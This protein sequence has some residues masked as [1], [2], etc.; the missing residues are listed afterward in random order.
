M[1]VK[2]TRQ[3]SDDLEAIGD[4]IARDN[5]VRAK[6]FVL[7]LRDACIGLGEFPLRYPIARFPF[8]PNVRQ[9]FHGSHAIQYRVDGDIVW[10]MHIVH[11]ARLA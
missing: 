4:H 9:R 3:A 6:S 7:E 5:P 10:I 2:F 11:A 8:A 1:I